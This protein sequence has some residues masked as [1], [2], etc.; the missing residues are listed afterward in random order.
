MNSNV[1]GVLIRGPSGIGKSTAVRGL[2]A[3]LPEL[4]V[5]TG[6][7]FGCDPGQAECPTCQARAAERAPL[8]STRRRIRIVNLPL[9][10][11]EDRVA[12]SLDLERA[13]HDGVKALEPGLLAEA[14]RGILYVDEINLLDDHLSDLL[15]DAAALGVNIV[16]RE[17][18][19]VS[20]PAHFLLVGT[21]NP[22][23][24]DLRVQIAD[25]IGLH[26][27]VEALTD[28]EQRA[29]IMRRREAF[30]ADP[31][32]FAA[33]FTEDEEA[34]NT[35]VARAVELIGRVRVPDNLYRAIAELVLS[36]GIASHRADIALLECAKALAALDGRDELTPRD[37]RD[38]AAMA[39]GHRMTAEAFGPPPTIEEQQ[40][41]RALDEILAEEVEAPKKCRRRVR[42]PQAD[43]RLP[44]GGAA[45][46]RRAPGRRPADARR[47]APTRSGGA[48][49]DWPPGPLAGAAPGGSLHA[50]AEGAVARRRPGA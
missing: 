8:P 29:E 46:R 7:A 39:L 47:G 32:A 15:L 16:E 43:A 6:C 38:A 35:R 11:T 23:E 44:D 31:E 18:I 1:G 50:R 2:A 21:M 13:L 14:N 22:E 30:A 9:N 36:F 10:A 17:G 48:R 28:P 27:D 24:G 41:E 37:V 3:L 42:R 49:R 19:A 12:G 34:L 26:V 5:V 20:H 33:S 40:L 45:G 25:R 4:D